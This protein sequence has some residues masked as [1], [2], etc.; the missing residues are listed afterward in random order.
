MVEPNLL[1]HGTR[2]DKIAARSVTYSH[3]QRI[4]SFSWMLADRHEYFSL[5]DTLIIIIGPFSESRVNL[6]IVRDAPSFTGA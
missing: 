5:L 2:V 1:E 4:P 3:L 6:Y